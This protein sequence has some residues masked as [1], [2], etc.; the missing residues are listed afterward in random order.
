MIYVSSLNSEVMRRRNVPQLYFA[1][2]TPSM[3]GRGTKTEKRTSRQYTDTK[4]EQ[5]VVDV[6]GMVSVQPIL[7]R[8][9]DRRD[10]QSETTE[11][12]IREKRFQQGLGR[13]CLRNDSYQKRRRIEI[14]SNLAIEDYES[15]RKE[16]RRRT[17]IPEISGSGSIL[18]HC[19]ILY[20]TD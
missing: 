9:N 16:T 11:A 10:Q 8:L 3:Y 14:D 17:P 6:Y 20:T 4:K 12:R 18:L 1:E 15:R 13:R 5:Y 7:G 2:N 19:A